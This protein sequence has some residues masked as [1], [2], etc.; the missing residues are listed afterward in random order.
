MEFLSEDYENLKKLIEVI[1]DNN[2]N[3]KE[4]RVYLSKKASLKI[5]EFF[6]INSNGIYSSKMFTEDWFE[7]EGTVDGRLSDIIAEYSDIFS[8]YGICHEDNIVPTYNGHYIFL[9]Q[10]ELLEEKDE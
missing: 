9:H 3:T 6:D 7:I 8:L 4:D 1:L 2:Y 10:P 5:M